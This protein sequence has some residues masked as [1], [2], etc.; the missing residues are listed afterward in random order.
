[1][2][3]NVCTWDEFDGFCH[4]FN[5]ST[6]LFSIVDA[7]NGKE[8]ADTKIKGKAVDFLPL[9]FVLKTLT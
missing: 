4:G 1:M 6:H 8:A 9:Q 7:G 5:Q 3:N 2:R